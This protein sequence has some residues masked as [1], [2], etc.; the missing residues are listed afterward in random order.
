MS[1]V[2]RTRRKQGS[3]NARVDIRYDYYLDLLAEATG[4]NKSELVRQG[5]EM[6]LKKY[7]FRITG[8]RVL[9]EMPEEQERKLKELR[10]ERDK[11]S[12]VPQ[13]G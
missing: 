12:I 8:A 13:R 2:I 6:V 3:I 1:R 5:I 11:Q 9:I 4:I 10:E 7:E